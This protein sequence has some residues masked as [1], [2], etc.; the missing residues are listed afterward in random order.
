[1][2]TTSSASHANAAK[3]DRT[4]AKTPRQEGII[5]LYASFADDHVQLHEKKG[6]VKKISREKVERQLLSAIDE[7]EIPLEYKMSWYHAVSIYPSYL[8]SKVRARLLIHLPRCSSPQ[9]LRPSGKLSLNVTNCPSHAPSASNPT[10]ISTNMTRLPTMRPKK[11]R[12][13]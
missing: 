6:K 4:A 7:A 12:M 13:E 2:P 10:Q 11:P 1:M 3:G 9:T 8:R 5:T